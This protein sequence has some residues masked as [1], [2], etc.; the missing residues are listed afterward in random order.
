MDD[1]SVATAPALSM[2]ESAVEPAV[3]ADRA[4]M[5]PARWIVRHRSLAALIAIL[6][7]AAG[8]RFYNLAGD[9]PGL[10]CDEASRIYDAYSVLH[11]GADRWGERFPFYFKSL[12]D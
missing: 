6:V 4:A 10:F 3:T 1:Q 5:T 7:V 9:P 8:L 12:G 2:P 11:T